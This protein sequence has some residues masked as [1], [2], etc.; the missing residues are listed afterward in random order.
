MSNS[1]LLM[2]PKDVLL[3]FGLKH[4]FIVTTWAIK[5]QW[6]IFCNIIKK[7]NKYYRIRVSDKSA[8]ILWLD[9]E[10]REYNLE[11]SVSEMLD[12]IGCWCILSS[13]CDISVFSSQLRR[14]DIYKFYSDYTFESV[15]YNWSLSQLTRG[16]DPLA[17][18]AMLATIDLIRFEQ[19]ILFK[20]NK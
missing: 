11:P 5:R 10:L 18:T 3:I 4:P 9:E 16:R 8:I 7:K 15:W 12:V 1:S 17:L 6:R 2:T 20:Q 19:H 14:T 13:F